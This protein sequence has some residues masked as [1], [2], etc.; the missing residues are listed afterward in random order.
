MQV[1]IERHTDAAHLN[2]IVNHPDVYRYVRGSADGPLDLAPVI[3]GN[4]NVFALGGE[5]GAI[6][7]SR[8][9]PGLFE[10]HSQCLP[11]GRGQW[12]IDFTQACLQWIFTRTEAVECLTRVPDGNAPA[13]AL[14]KGIGG[15]LA[16]TVAN[17]WM[18]DGKVVP[19]DIYSL[20]IQD[21]MKT[22]PGLVE[23]GQWFHQRLEEEL[24]K[25]GKSELAHPDDDNHDRYVGAAVD[26]I[27]GGQP[28]KGV[29]FYNRFA[30]M[31]GYLPIILLSVDPVVVDVGTA[32]LE[33]RG[34][35]FAVRELPAA[36]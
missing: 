12:M 18:L 5:H 31:S 15:Q 19:A 26:M 10:G 21:W 11:Q 6:L 29:V 14:A 22:A 7:F 3:V 25:I 9:Q 8:V 17:G 1:A 27:S 16:F 4:D 34:D 36:A 13:K 28:H 20:T 23:R 24:A 32:I 35:D 2:S 30:A 33:M